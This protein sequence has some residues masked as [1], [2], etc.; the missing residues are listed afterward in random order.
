MGFVLL[1]LSETGGWGTGV[2]GDPRRCMGSVYGLRK[3]KIK[4]TKYVTRVYV[5]N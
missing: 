4:F 2:C 3:V 1:V 5:S